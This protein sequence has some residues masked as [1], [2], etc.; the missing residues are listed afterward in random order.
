MNCGS[1][2]PSTAPPYS[3]AVRTVCEGDMNAFPIPA[4]S[5]TFPPSQPPNHQVNLFLTLDTLYLLPKG[6][7][8]HPSSGVLCFALPRDT[9]DYWTGLSP[10][11]QGIGS[12]GLLWGTHT[13]FVPHPLPFFRCRTPILFWGTTS[14]PLS[15][16][17]IFTPSGSRMV[18]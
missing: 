15:A 14:P 7:P 6:F 17:V 2:V 12:S 13:V 8:V 11:D 4:H 16:Y 5:Y 1:L 3:N 10:T 9:E 18:M